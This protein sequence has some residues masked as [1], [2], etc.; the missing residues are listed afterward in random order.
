LS[1]PDA[2]ILTDVAARSSN[3]KISCRRRRA[4][5]SCSEFVVSDDHDGLKKAI[6]E[7]LSGVRTS[8]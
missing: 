7:C 2:A 3:M 1:R 4:A 8:P 6:A 5:G